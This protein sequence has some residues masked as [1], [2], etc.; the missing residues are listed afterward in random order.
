MGSNGAKS[1]ATALRFWGMY[2]LADEVER[3]YAPGKD[4]EPFHYKP[5]RNMI[6]FLTTHG[7]DLPRNP[8]MKVTDGRP[9]LFWKRSGRTTLGLSFMPDGKVAFMSER[10]NL[11][12]PFEMNGT[13]DADEAWAR[14][15][16]FWDG[17]MRLLAVD[18]VSLV[19]GNAPTQEAVT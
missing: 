1:A 16:S 5:V 10:Q 14:L 6:D 4:G 13:L 9:E 8:A 7:D 17:Q 12:G 15:V 18:D 11:G 19:G 3:I 2:S